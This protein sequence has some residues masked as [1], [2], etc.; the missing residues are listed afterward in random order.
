MRPRLFTT[1]HRALG[2][3][4]LLLALSAVIAGTLLSL[5]MRLHRVWPDCAFPFFGMLKPEGYL[6]LVTMHGTLMV[7]FVLTVAP[8]IGFANL[9]L[10]EQIGARGMAFPAPEC[11]GLLDDGRGASCPAR[12]LSSCRRARPSRDGPAI[13]R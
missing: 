3:L 4:Y 2:I 11:R 6:A 9:V 8:Q 7:F 12:A 1:S 13:P 5:V 10:P